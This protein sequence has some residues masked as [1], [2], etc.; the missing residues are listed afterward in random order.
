MRRKLCEDRDVG[1]KVNNFS[2]KG[3]ARHGLGDKSA[4]VCFFPIKF[5]FLPQSA[6][7]HSGI[8]F[9]ALAVDEYGP[10]Q[11]CR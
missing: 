2:E 11:G 6:F 10:S 5:F 9:T 8:T 1:K 3:Q 7:W 4:L